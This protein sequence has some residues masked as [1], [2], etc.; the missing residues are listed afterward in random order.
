M[1]TN[2]EIVKH[3][4]QFPGEIHT[5]SF[6]LPGG[7]RF[8]VEHKYKLR[9]ISINAEKPMGMM[10]VEDNFYPP[11][12]YNLTLYKGRES[13][14][15][16]KQISLLISDRCKVSSPTGYPAGL[17]PSFSPTPWQGTT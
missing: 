12:P 1:W 2:K 5:E 7:N 10:E 16:L 14:H 4:Q 17:S 13:R 15:V 6:P 11:P 8:R 3:L 9:D